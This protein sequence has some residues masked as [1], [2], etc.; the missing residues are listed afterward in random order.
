VKLVNIIL[1]AFDSMFISN[2]DENEAI[3][4]AVSGDILDQYCVLRDDA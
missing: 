3:F 1:L 2:M 4:T